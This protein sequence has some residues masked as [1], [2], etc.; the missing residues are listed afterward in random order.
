[1]IIKSTNHDD[2]SVG[3]DGDGDEDDNDVGHVG[4][5]GCYDENDGR[6][7]DDDGDHFSRVTAE[8][9]LF[10]K[11]TTW[12]SRSLALSV[13][14]ENRKKGNWTFQPKYKQL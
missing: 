10:I 1:M 5:G 4:G 14:G 9:H 8:D 12:S 11:T 6:D 13:M 2:D 3:H 7:G